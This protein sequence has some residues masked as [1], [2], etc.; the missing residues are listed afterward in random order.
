MA[1]TA[2]QRESNQ[3]NSQKS[4]GP[5]S[6]EG[7]AR[8]RA[9]SLKH[10]LTG[11][12]VVLAVED[13]PEIDRR[14]ESLEADLAPKNELARRHL[15]RAAF[16]DLR[17]ERCALHE[18]KVIDYR[19]RQ[20]VA[21]FDDA[22]LAEVEKAISWI[23]AEPATHARRLR[24]SLEGIDT[25]IEKFKGLRKDLLR[26]HGIIWTYHHCE[27]IHHL[28]G[29]RRGDLPISRARC[30]GEA[31][32][33]TMDLLT[34]E[35]GP[36]LSV[37][38]RKLWAAD[39]LIELIEVELAS[40]EALK[41]TIDVEAIALDRAEAPYRAMFD[42]SKEAILARKYEAATERAY[43]KAMIGFEAAQDLPPQ[44][45]EEQQFD[46]VPSDELGS[47]C[48]PDPEPDDAQESADST[49]SP[50]PPP[51]VPQPSLTPSG[52]AF[53]EVSADSIT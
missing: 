42:P 10:G 36:G 16:L 41:A 19:M 24:G 39:R 21:C 43:H 32:Y 31:I 8:S 1:C 49:P 34:P 48:P 15:A 17:L 12:G 13:A 7:K 53:R 30:L 45:E 33:G 52:S 35:D 14:C 50:T 51:A 29:Q 20:A 6:E 22:R 40:L 11:A 23:A 47:F 4:T 28:M 26:P 18:A 9:N 46:P 37:Q 3:K 44:V 5:K 38:E 2:K 27:T 25:L